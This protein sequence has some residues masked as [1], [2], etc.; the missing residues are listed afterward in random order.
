[1]ATTYPLKDMRGFIKNY[2]LANHPNII[3]GRDYAYIMPVYFNIKNLPY[4]AFYN[5]AGQ[6]I[7]GIWRKYDHRKNIAGTPQIVPLRDI[8]NNK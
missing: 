7:K 1:M 4:H 8:E 6:L 5:K 3:I 2:N